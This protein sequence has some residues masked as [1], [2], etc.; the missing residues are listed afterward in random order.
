VANM[1]G[2]SESTMAGYSRH[3]RSDG[4]NTRSHE[5]LTSLRIL[6]V[7]DNW[8]ARSLLR[9]V[10][11]TLGVWTLVECASPKEAF[12]KLEEETFDL[13]LLDNDMPEMSGIEM[14][15]HIR[16]SNV[17]DDPSIPIIMISSRTELEEVRQAVNA[18][19]HEYLAKPFTADGLVKKVLAG[20]T[21]YRQFI[22]SSAYV[23]PCRRRQK[24]ML[25]SHGADRRVRTGSAMVA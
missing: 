24:L 3:T 8:F 19:I 6:I 15:R 12:Q 11:Q 20:A 23:G 21:V 16:S 1:V 22:R 5:R 7:D 9:T 25:K 2:N 17:I 14:T 18:G 4:Q 10:L 13:I